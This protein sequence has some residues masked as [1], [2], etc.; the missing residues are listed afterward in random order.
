MWPCST[1][2]IRFAWRWSSTPAHAGSASSRWTA[3]IRSS[4]DLPAVE[5][6][7]V[8]LLN[9]HP[10]DLDDQLRQAVSFLHS[11][12]VPVNWH[13][14]LRDVCAWGH[15][16]RYVQRRWAGAFWGAPEA[17]PDAKPEANE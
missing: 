6:R 8:A 10:D 1:P 7:F 16:E 5:R 9:T 2:T 14:L 15:P 3:A 11:K 13:Q 4:G 17:N 12:D